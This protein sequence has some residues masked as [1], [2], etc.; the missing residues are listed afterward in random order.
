[1]M[2][3]KAPLRARDSPPVFHNGTA[4]QQ[5]PAGFFPRRGLT[6]FT[7]HHDNGKRK[8]YR[9]DARSI[10]ACAIDGVRR[11]RTDLSKVF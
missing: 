4:G 8:V 11:F 6:L 7:S 1:M 3:R 9:P 2:R 5:S 10:L